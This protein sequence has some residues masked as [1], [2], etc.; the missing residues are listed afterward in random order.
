M[1]VLVVADDCNPEWASLPIVGYR[2]AKAIA[3]RV[4]TVVATHVRNRES[5]ERHGF[6]KAT[7]VY[8]DNE[9]INSPLYRLG[10]SV[11]G[12]SRAGWTTAIAV[13][14][15]SI[16]A[17]EWEVW[18]RFRDELKAGR[19]DVVH[20]ITPMSPALPSLL[21]TLSP[22]PFVLGPLNGGL[23]W[24]DQFE[25]E[26]Q[27]E[28]EYL[29]YVRGVHKY[30]PFYRSTYRKS[31]A[32]LA[33]FRHTVDDL[34]ESARDRIVDF[35]EVGLDPETFAVDHLELAEDRPLTFLFAGRFVPLKLIDVAIR[36]FAETPALRAHRLLL[37]G[38]GMEREVL[39][40]QIA[41][42]KLEGVVEITG[43]RSIDE[44][45]ALM[46]EADVF[47]FPSI[48]DLGAGVVIQA[49]G[50]GCAPIV[51]DYGGPGGLVVEGA[52]I[53]IPLA[54]RET[55]VAAVAE[56]CL[57]YVN[58]RELLLR[59]ATQARRHAIEH[60]TWDAKARKTIEIYEWA[61]GQRSVKPTFDGVAAAGAP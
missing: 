53:K 8:I 45:G 15:P 24:P 17:F 11:R 48:R 36:A 35:P 26:M 55:L 42:A 9:Y 37:V 1:R 5:I 52:G 51:V 57:R 4:E 10:K 27:K 49:M 41:A 3:E 2:A 47:L 30:L 23:S 40:R 21:A 14:Y 28:R 46:R 43:W 59:H 20:R 60:Y 54:S 32:I 56:A 34:P 38:D 29:T 33:S 12:G 16:L 25:S 19:F 22:V 50:A 39:E 18:K 13:A 44:V 6:G 7:T 58:D 61:C 31:A